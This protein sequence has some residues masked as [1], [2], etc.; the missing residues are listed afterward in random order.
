MT[1]EFSSFD[2]SLCGEVARA[3]Y[4]NGTEVTE[5]SEP[6]YKYGDSTTFSCYSDDISLIGKNADY[7]IHAYFVEYQQ[8][9]GDET[10]IFTGNIK[11]ETPCK[12]PTSLSNEPE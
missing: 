10:Y 6:V 2:V 3:I 1:S 7:E 11:F 5:T 12:K 4:F 9:R 8:Y